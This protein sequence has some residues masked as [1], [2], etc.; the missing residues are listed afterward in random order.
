[1]TGG[2][3][4]NPF[5]DST[6]DNSLANNFAEYF[7][8]KIKKIRTDLD[9]CPKFESEKRNC[10]KLHKLTPFSQDEVLRIITGMASKSCELEP[11][12]TKVLKAVIQQLFNISPS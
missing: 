10:S 9:N 4:E 8:N 3:K 11:L 2:T 7:L 1:M 12:P 6:D 5:P